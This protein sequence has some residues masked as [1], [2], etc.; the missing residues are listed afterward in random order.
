[1]RTETRIPVAEEPGIAALAMATVE[2]AKRWGRAEIAY[3]KALAGERGVDAGVG[4]GLALGAL[5]L[6][7]AALIALL[8]GLVLTL[9]PSTGPGVATLIVVA[10]TLAIAGI[11]GMVALA[12]FRRAARPIGSERA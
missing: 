2:D 9:T 5:A 1:M 4:T 12:R 3:Y 6:A 8:V 7:Q 10:V 11:V